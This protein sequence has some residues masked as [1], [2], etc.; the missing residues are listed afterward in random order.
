M[1]RDNF[2]T[3]TSFVIKLKTKFYIKEYE[4]NAAFG[5]TDKSVVFMDLPL[6]SLHLFPSHPIPIL[7]PSATIYL[8]HRLN[9]F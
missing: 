1:N 6:A 8:K 7:F 2:T 5:Y 9:I 4:N 3:V